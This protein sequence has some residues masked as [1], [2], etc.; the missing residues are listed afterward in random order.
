[1][2]RATSYSDLFRLL[3]PDYDPLHIEAYVRLEYATLDHLDMPTLRRE[4]A[5]AAAC[6]DEVGAAGAD[7]CA[8]SMGLLSIDG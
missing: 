6:V 8:V 5:I 3:Q 4:A 1:M 2:T 7:T